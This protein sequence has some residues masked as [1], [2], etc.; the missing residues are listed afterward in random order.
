M[1]NN[2]SRDERRLFTWRQK[3]SLLRAAGFK[4][5]KCGVSVADSLWHAHHVK[6]HSNG[7]QTEIYNGMILCDSCHLEEHHGV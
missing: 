5:Q 3:L 2:K 6:E 7:G 4:C 1:A